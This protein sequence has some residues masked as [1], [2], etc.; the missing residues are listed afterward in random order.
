MT[1]IVLKELIL[2]LSICDRARQTISKDIYLRNVIDMIYLIDIYIKYNILKTRNISFQG[3]M[4]YSPKLT[5]EP[6]K[7]NKFCS[8]KDI[9]LS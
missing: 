6:K 2:P 7:N 1:H 9:L 3:L 8:I 5:I 4:D